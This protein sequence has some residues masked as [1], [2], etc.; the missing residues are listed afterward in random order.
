MAKV[1]NSIKIIPKQLTKSSIFSQIANETGLTKKD[2][3]AVFDSLANIIKKNLSGRKAPGIFTLPGLVKI[4]VMKKA[5]TKARKGTNPF[6][7]KAMIIKAKPATKV[8]KVA[9]LKRLKDMI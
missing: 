7:G 1:N 9:A 4:K 6:N 8:I 3:A 2:I 5:A